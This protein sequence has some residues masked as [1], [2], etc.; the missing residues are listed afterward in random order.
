MRVAT[1]RTP[2]IRRTRRYTGPGVFAWFPIEYITEELAAETL[3]A[4][5]MREGRERVVGLYLVY[6]DRDMAGPGVQR[7]AQIIRE[8]TTAEC[9]IRGD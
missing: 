3:K 5:P 4:L 6:A 9:R 7:L 8:R 1:D 2:A